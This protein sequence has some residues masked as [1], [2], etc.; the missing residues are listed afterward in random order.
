MLILMAS[1]HTRVPRQDPPSSPPGTSK[2]NLLLSSK[3]KV[4]PQK[5]VVRR[6][7]PK[8]RP[9][10]AGRVIHETGL[11]HL[12]ETDPGTA[13]SHI[14][15]PFVQ[16]MRSKHS[17][18][19]TELFAYQ[20]RARQGLF[21]WVNQRDLLLHGAT[22]AQLEALAQDAGVPQAAGVL[23]DVDGWNNAN[24][25]ALQGVTLVTDPTNCG[26]LTGQVPG[27][28]TL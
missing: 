12:T 28:T 5:D 21:T 6:E 16:W 3:T 20:A 27:A 23:V 9:A 19:D 4:S 10:D 1:S 8:E 17:G 2:N 15:S 22:M 11:L 25:N 26:Q 7:F 24:A 13:A 18:M 14:Y